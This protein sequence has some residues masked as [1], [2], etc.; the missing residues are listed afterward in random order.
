MRFGLGTRRARRLLI[1]ALAPVLTGCA[2]ASVRQQ[3]LEAQQLNQVGL[4]SYGAG[5]RQAAPALSGT[6]L[7]G[8]QFTLSSTLGK[9]VVIN[10]WASWCTPCRTESP[11]LA[12]AAK[13]FAGQP[14][15]FLGIDERDGTTQARAFVTA[16]G[17]PYPSL[18]DSDGTLL[19]RLRVLPQAAVPSTLILDRQ[20]RI[21]DRVIGAVTQP[22]IEGLITGL[23]KQS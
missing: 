10:V 17:V 13:H 14:V 23:L 22:Q 20:G 3:A 1:V 5:S 8:S 11:A 19:G 4:T 15:Q 6:T 18:V 21:A 16:V 9:V 2:A 7:D 12:R